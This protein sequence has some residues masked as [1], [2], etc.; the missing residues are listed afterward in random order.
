MHTISSLLPSYVASDTRIWSTA[1]A[2]S[3]GH[4]PTMCSFRCSGICSRGTS[5]R[6][7]CLAT[8]PAEPR[9]VPRT[10]EQEPNQFEAPHS[11]VPRQPAAFALRHSTHLTNAVAGLHGRVGLAGAHS[12]GSHISP[13]L[14]LP[15]C[16]AR[17]P[18]Y[19]TASSAPW[20]TT[21]WRP[22][23]PHQRVTRR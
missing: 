22:R 5:Q 19:D 6:P 20:Q 3:L 12:C 9:G 16:A 1:R 4:C 21:Q 15:Q 10:F 17:R 13:H 18:L 7:H 14:P 2:K 8:F 23:S 11:F